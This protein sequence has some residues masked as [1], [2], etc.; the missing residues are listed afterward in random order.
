[1]DADQ[2]LTLMEDRG[3]SKRSVREATALQPRGSYY[4][5]MVHQNFPHRENVYSGRSTYHI[6]HNH[7]DNTKKTSPC[8]RRLFLE[9]FERQGGVL[10]VEGGDRSVRD[11]A[12]ATAQR[13]WDHLRRSRQWRDTYFKRATML[14]LRILGL[15]HPI[16]AR[17]LHPIRAIS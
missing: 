13:A 5:L 4:L 16:L 7:T 2:A 9:E 11:L 3:H 17:A 15:T 8:N 12:L 1:M 10:P 14:L 6:P